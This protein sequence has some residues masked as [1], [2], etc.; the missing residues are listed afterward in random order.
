MSADEI[1]ELRIGRD[2]F[3]VPKFT[4]TKALKPKNIAHAHECE[5]TE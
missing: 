3:V 5:R 1:I 2:I 4:Y